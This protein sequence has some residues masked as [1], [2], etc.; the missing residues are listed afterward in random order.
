MAVAI[1]PFSNQAS[2]FVSDQDFGTFK[3]VGNS[4]E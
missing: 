2:A 1:A 4:I 3:A